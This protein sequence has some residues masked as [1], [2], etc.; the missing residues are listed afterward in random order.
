MD[1]GFEGGKFYVEYSGCSRIPG[2][3]REEALVR[4]QEIYASNPKVMLCLSSGLD[5]QIALYSFMSQSIP[6]E[7]AFLRMGGYNENE[8]EN[9]KI[10]EKKWGFKATVIDIDPNGV[11]DELEHLKVELD[12]HAN[13][14]LQYKFVSSLPEDYSIVQVLHD[15]WTITTRRDSKHYLFHGYYDPEIGRHRVLQKIQRSGAIHMFGDSSEFFLSCLSDPLFKQFFNSWIYYDGNGLTQY[16]R[17]LPDLLR[18]EYYIKPLL[19]SKHWGGD[20][21]YFPKFSGYE[22]IE[23]LMK[24]VRVMRKQNIVLVEWDKLVSHLETIGAPAVKYWQ[25]PQGYLDLLKV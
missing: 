15:P 13:H 9:V 8:L 25:L 16:G 24:E 18:Y 11:R 12:A 6:V 14:C 3:L 7:C 2:S 20:L 22:N 23:W 10:L 21:M 1:Y 4:A 17:K 5:S 19:Y